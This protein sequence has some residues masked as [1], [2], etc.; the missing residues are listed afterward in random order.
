M[1]AVGL[2][3]GRDGNSNPRPT[4]SGSDMY[5]FEVK[6]RIRKKGSK[7][8]FAHHTPKEEEKRD[9]LNYEIQRNPL[10]PRRRDRG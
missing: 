10:R 4:G 7:K 8:P 1:W 5:A 9:H 2:G 6:G 3:V